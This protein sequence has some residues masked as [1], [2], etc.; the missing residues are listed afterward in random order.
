MSIGLLTACFVTS[1]ASCPAPQAPAVSTPSL[2]T[3]PVT[4]VLGMLAKDAL[5]AFE[6]VVVRDPNVRKKPN[7][8]T[9]Q[10]P[11]SNRPNRIVPGAPPPPQDVF[12]GGPRPTPQPN[13]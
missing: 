5:P 8:G 3:S 12:P 4:S 2:V 7:P 6:Q 11:K 10:P 1:I 9:S 13:S